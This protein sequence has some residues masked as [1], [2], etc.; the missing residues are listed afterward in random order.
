VPPATKSKKPKATHG[1]TADDVLKAGKAVQPRYLQ[2]PS[3]YKPQQA[4]GYVRISLDPY[5][6]ER[7]V[8]RQVQDIHAKADQLGWRVAK[9]YRENDTSA[10]HKKKLTQPDGSVIWRV[11]RPRWS[12]M[13][14]DLMTG[15]IDG[16]I[17]YDQDRLL[18]Q[19]RDLEDLIDI[20]DIV[21]KPVAG[22]TSGINL[23]TSEGR[24]IARIMAAVALKS[25][26][27]TAR[28]VERAK[29]QDA[30]DATVL[31]MRRFGRKKRGKL[32]KAEQEAAEAAADVILA[33]GKWY[34]GTRYLE[35][36]SGVR[37]VHGGR[38]QDATVRNMLLNPT[39]AGIAIYRGA[40]R[41]GEGL[42]PGRMNAADPAS[43]ALR[44]SKGRYLK[45]GWA[46]VI[47]VEKWE[48][49]CEMVRQA[50]DGTA[51]PIIGAKKYQ[52]SGLVRCANIREN[53]EKC[54]CAWNGASVKRPTKA[55]P[56]KRVVMYRCPGLG[57]GGCGRLSRDGLTLEG[58]IDDLFYLYLTTKAPTGPHVSKG[59]VRT[60]AKELAKAE[61]HLAECQH[62]LDDLRT[63]YAEP[64]RA[65]KRDEELT[66]ESFFAML[67]LLEGAVRKARASVDEL[68][69]RATP[70][71]SPEQVAEEYRRADADG[72][73]MILGRYLVAIEVGP[74]SVRGSRQFDPSAVT[75]IW[76]GAANQKADALAL[77]A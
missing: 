3:T 18:R 59:A 64:D 60:N 48:A 62:R 19:P 46:P 29:L 2:G 8:K 71:K 51:P 6:L 26:E 56:G 44:D 45:T 55:N 33:T 58:F 12:Q 67:P 32:I 34:Q 52:L 35:N 5:G 20:I 21:K 7:G 30:I 13:L 37:P 24:T 40:M 25:S 75:P 17:V 65:D 38:W 70:T 15:I 27:D 23:M 31:R 47:P 49:L 41:Q 43:D 22:I 57:K 66:K 14:N 9:V 68:R 61:K 39:I 16:I 73:R 54:G 69:G 28:R 63:R 74:S 1:V 50:H 53:G 76:K 42:A 77:A 36:E 11:V 72:K 4:A 10:Y